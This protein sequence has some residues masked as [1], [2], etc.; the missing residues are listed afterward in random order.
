[1]PVD[2]IDGTENGGGQGKIGAQCL[3]RRGAGGRC[4]LREN[5]ARI[6]CHESEVVQFVSPETCFQSINYHPTTINSPVQFVWTKTG[7]ERST[8]NLR[9][10]TMKVEGWAR[11]VGCSVR[12]GDLRRFLDG[13]RRKSESRKRLRSLGGTM[14]RF[15]QF[16]WAKAVSFDGTDGRTGSGWEVRELI[17]SFWQKHDNVPARCPSPPKQQRSQRHLVTRHALCPLRHARVISSF[18]QKREENVQ[19]RTS[20]A[21]HRRREGGG[22]IGAPAQSFSSFGQISSHHAPCSQRC[23]RVIAWCPRGRPSSA[24]LVARPWS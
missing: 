17:S 6:R 23:A 15:V 18:W 1:M 19:H 2:E 10:S 12:F 22:L 20:N 4:G 13:G 9:R 3:E 21:H 7:S 8:S 11:S 14:H 24:G 16:G 5:P